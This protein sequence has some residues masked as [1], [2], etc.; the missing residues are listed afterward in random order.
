MPVDLRTPRMERLFTPNGGAFPYFHR[1]YTM[2]GSG[3]SIPRAFDVAGR[4]QQITQAV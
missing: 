2:T 1:L 4:S 3:V